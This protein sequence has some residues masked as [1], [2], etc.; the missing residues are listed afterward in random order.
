MAIARKIFSQKMR[1]QYLG[2]CDRTNKI[3]STKM[4]SPSSQYC[5]RTKKYSLKK[6]DRSI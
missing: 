3:F 2:Y 5:D 1:S 4:R 6:C